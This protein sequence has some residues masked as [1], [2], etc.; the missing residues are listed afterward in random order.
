M[1]RRGLT[2]RVGRL[3]LGPALGL[4][5]LAAGPAHAS[6]GGAYA[7]VETDRAHL[8][9]RA[10]TA[11]SAAFTVHSL[12]LA[13]GATVRE[14]T[15]ADG[16]VFAIAWQGPGRPDLRQ[17]LGGYFDTFQAENGLKA[18]RRTRR[19]LQVQHSDFVVQTSGHPG[20]FRGMAVL[21]QLAPAGF[22]SDD[23]K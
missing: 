16:T 22:S 1:V 6:L 9:A 5:A 8:A 17:L 15:R 18:G 23:L 3:A 13:N 21:P 7:S 11:Q 19:P 4:A 2:A 14:F 10:S 20:A 12:T